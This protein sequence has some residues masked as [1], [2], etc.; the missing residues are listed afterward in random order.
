MK[1]HDSSDASLPGKGESGLVFTPE[2]PKSFLVWFYLSVFCNFMCF[3]INTVFSAV[4]VIERH[5]TFRHSFYTI[6]LVFSLSVVISSLCKLIYLL[7]GMA[8]LH[9]KLF[10]CLSANVDLLF[11]YFSAF[12]IFLLGLNRFAAFSSPYLNEKLMKRKTLIS[13]LFGLLLFSAMVTILIYVLSGLQRVFN[14]A[15]IT[16]YA[17]TEHYGQREKMLSVMSQSLY[18]MPPKDAL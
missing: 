2:S 4:S 3:A 12:L 9:I 6:V 13:I 18:W 1:P 10:D 8:G 14:P 17:T 16:D 7:S 15:S 5:R 11:S